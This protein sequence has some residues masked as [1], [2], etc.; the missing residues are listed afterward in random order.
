ML[1]VNTLIVTSTI[2]SP[3]SP[4][5]IIPLATMTQQPTTLHQLSKDDTAGCQTTILSWSRCHRPSDTTVS[6]NILIPPGELPSSAGMVRLQ[7]AINR[8]ERL[9]HAAHVSSSA[10]SASICQFLKRKN[11]MLPGG[12]RCFHEV[13]RLDALSIAS[14]T[15]LHPAVCH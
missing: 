14:G 13:G 7:T 4:F 15:P 3:T 11:C 9:S 6:M 10:A 1:L 8:R 2:I 12:Q 5:A